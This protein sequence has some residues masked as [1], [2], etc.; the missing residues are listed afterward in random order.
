MAGE[1]RGAAGG[2]IGRL[3]DVEADMAMSLSQMRSAEKTA[4]GNFQKD[5]Q[6][7]KLEKVQKDW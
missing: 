7:M 3:E 4:A 2:I 5:M 1:R 6:D